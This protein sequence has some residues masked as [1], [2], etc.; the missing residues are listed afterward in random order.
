MQHMK[1]D[2]ISLRISPDVR[3]AIERAAADDQRSVSSLL[4]KIVTDW[5]RRGGWLKEP[6]TTG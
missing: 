6:K 5:A 1:T 4:A 2:A 3:Q